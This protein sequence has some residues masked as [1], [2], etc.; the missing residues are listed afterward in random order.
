[1]ADL[2]RSEIQAIR[3]ALAFPR[4]PGYVLG[5]SD[6]TFDEYFQ[7]EFG[8]NIYS[9]QFDSNGTSKCNRLLSYLQQSD[10]SSSLRVLRSLWDLRE[11]LLSEHEGQLDL[12]SA[13]NNGE[14]FRKV[15]ERLQ[16]EPDSFST[17][18]IQAFIP[19]R[20]L[21][22]LVADIERSLSANKPEVA[23]D[24]LHTYCMKRFSHLLRVRGIDYSDDEPLHSRFGKYR[25]QLISERQLHEF[26]E[27]ALKSF[28]SLL[29]SF[30]DLRNNHSLAHDNK[31]LETFE[32]RFIF[33]SINSMLV[34]IR[35]LEA[36]RYES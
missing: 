11:G 28:I 4:G 30:N 32:A 13:V 34:M 33:S 8:V 27:R 35:T 6:R 17:D 19:D 20:T 7:D 14:S 5:F 24:H 18:G 10:N 15:I 3:N 31:I 36:G 16:G 23:I 12:K 9:T 1:M 26:T 2:K 29:E 25:K 21:E 22:E